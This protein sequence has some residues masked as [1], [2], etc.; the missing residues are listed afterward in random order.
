MIKDFTTNIMII[1]LTILIVFIL[2]TLIGFILI[3]YQD[4]EGEMSILLGTDED[5]DSGFF[6]LLAADTGLDSG[7]DDSSNVIESVD[8]GVSESPDEVEGVSESPDENRD[9][10]ISS[11]LND[12]FN[13][14]GLNHLN[15][16]MTEDFQF[17]V[18]DEEN[19]V[20]SEEERK[21]AQ[22][23]FNLT[24]GQDKDKVFQEMLKK[25]QDTN[26]E[27]KESSKAK[28]DIVEEDLPLKEEDLSENKK[29]K[30]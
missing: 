4:F 24:T 28:R 13:S 12:R 29:Q 17:T 10:G 16:F 1:T 8:K 3:A 2:I 20:L 30:K 23:N 6:Y 26:I 19:P 7:I 22:D 14:N 21:E 27:E 9:P 18:D 25:L 5:L 11:Y 15:Q